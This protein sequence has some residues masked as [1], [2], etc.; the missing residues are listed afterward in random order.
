[1]AVHIQIAQFRG[2][3]LHLG[4]KLKKGDFFF[5]FDMLENLSW[6]CFL[7]SNKSAAGE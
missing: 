2:L 4:F 3:S 7:I 1:M 6:D 5:S